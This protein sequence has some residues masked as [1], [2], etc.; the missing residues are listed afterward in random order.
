MPRLRRANFFEGKEMSTLWPLGGD[1][2]IRVLFF[3]DRVVAGRGRA[4]GAD[5]LHGLHDA[6]QN[7]LK[8]LA[9]NG[10]PIGNRTRATAV[11]GQCP[12]R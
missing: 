6:E 10:D 2:R 3:L 7:A 11:K 1:A 4:D 8:V 5:F 12:N 9:K